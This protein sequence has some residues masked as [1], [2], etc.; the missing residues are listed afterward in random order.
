MRKTTL[1]FT[2]FSL[3][4]YYGNCQD[5]LKATSG[6]ISSELNFNPLAGSFSFNN[7]SAQIKIRK[8]ISERKALR[9]AISTTYLQNKTSSNSSYGYNPVHQNINQKALTTAL[10]VGIEKHLKGTKRLSPYIGWELGFAIK[11]SNEIDKDDNYKTTIDGS[12]WKREVLYSNYGYTI[13][14]SFEETG[15]WSLSG[16]IVAGIDFYVAKDF[17]LGVEIAYGINYF[18]YSKIKVTETPSS[19]Y[20]YPDIESEKWSFGPKLLNGIRIGFVF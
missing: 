3:L 7:A 11:N 8:F 1:L 19:G 15:Y 5:T 17:Y 13:K 6:R 9:I 14:T 20:T 18:K 2:F 10:N 16:N 12:W 4:T